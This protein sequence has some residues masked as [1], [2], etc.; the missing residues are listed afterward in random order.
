[1]ELFSIDHNAMQAARHTD[2]YFGVVCVAWPNF[3]THSNIYGCFFPHADCPLPPTSPA[4][5]RTSTST[6]CFMGDFTPETVLLMIAGCAKSQVT[7]L[8]CD[9]SF[10]IHSLNNINEINI[11]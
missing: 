11:T 7:V 5:C 2:L 10:G 8:T 6:R 4:G 3:T 1:M 9:K